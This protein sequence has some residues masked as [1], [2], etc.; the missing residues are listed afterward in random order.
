MA[1]ENEI[2]E[3]IMVKEEQDGSVTVDLPDSIP[4]PDQD[5]DGGNEPVSAGE[6]GGD[7]D[8]VDREGD[9]EAI[10][11]ARRNRRRA[12]KEYVK[13]T[14][15]EKDQRLVMLQRQN[16]DL[17]ER[18]S[19]VERKTH[20]ADLARLDKAIEDKELRLQ[21]ARMKMSESTSA[22]DGEAFA[23]AQEMWYETRREVESMKSLKDN[24]VRSANVQ[25]PA[26][27]QELQRQAAKWMDRNDWFA[28][29]GGDEDSEIAKII[30]QKLVKEGWNP[31]SEEYW[32]ELDKR[33]Q[34]RLPHRYTDD[35]DE[36]NS[37]TSRRP[38]SIVTGSGREGTTSSGSR[39]TFVLAPEQV[40]A[41]KDAGL[42]DNQQSRNRMIKRYAEQARSQ[43][44]GYRS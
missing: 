27:S 34:K 43:N 1:T 38:R 41:I 7:E 33:L 3:K 10:R 22:G 26:N 36:R 21:Y 16:Q 32:Q 31:S 40:R 13:K 8:D 18:L 35:N 2:D 4:S 5:E 15:E 37:R 44:S 20:S 12:K 42:W 25:S 23:K 6:S 24:A 30:D 29:D 14:N 17:M 28:P 9:T 19:N 11:A 39:N